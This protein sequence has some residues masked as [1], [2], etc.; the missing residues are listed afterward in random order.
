[1][2]Y[3]LAEPVCRIFNISLSSGVVPTIWKEAIITPVLKT[4]NASSE[5]KICP[6]S[7]TEC[8]SKILENL[9]MMDDIMN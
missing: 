7:L 6:I 2:L 9:M 5:H 4:Q 8:L 3:E 1:M